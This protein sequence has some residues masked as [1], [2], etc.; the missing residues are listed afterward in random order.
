MLRRRTRVTVRCL[1]EDLS[2]DVPDVLSAFEVTDRE[3]VESEFE[4]AG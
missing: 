1:R 4:V 2:L 3:S